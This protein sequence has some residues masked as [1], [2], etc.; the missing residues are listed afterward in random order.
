MSDPEAIR[1]RVRC[2]ECKREFTWEGNSV[3]ECP[4]MYHAYC[5]NGRRIRLRNSLPRRCPNPNKK[6]FRD[7]DSAQRFINNNYRPDEMMAPYR[8]ACQGIHIGHV[9]AVCEAKLVNGVWLVNDEEKIARKFEQ[10]L[11]RRRYGRL[12]QPVKQLVGA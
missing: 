9:L 12:P 10:R 1:W 6:P 2:Y 11:E 4:P 7:S 5:K 3:N 8:C